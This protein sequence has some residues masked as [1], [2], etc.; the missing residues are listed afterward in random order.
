M[1]ILRLLFLLC[2]ACFIIPF[3][4]KSSVL[5]CDPFHIDFTK[6]LEVAKQAVWGNTNLTATTGNGLAESKNCSGNECVE[7]W[8]KTAAYPM[9][10]KWR[11]TYAT[12]FNVKLVF[13]SGKTSSLL[14][15]SITSYVRYS[16]DL[17]HWSSW[18]AL[19]N[20]SSP[21]KNKTTE[22]N[23]FSFNGGIQIPRIASPLYSDWW[24]KYR[25]LKGAYAS[26]DEEA[27]VSWILSQDPSFFEKEIP[28]IGYTQL[29][30][31]VTFY[32]QD[33]LKGIDIQRITCIGGTCVMPPQDASLQDRSFD[34]YWNFRALT[35]TPAFP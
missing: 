18:I 32:G 5:V 10:C 2:L 22:P 35:N 15:P 14:P 7:T 29:L 12:S 3:E 17:K 26:E 20:T 4:A 31:E 30:F 8:I 21:S 24:D 16:P 28:F 25:K 27:L 1:K 13:A 11:T 19:P 34:S 33:S 6:P 23:V 9:H